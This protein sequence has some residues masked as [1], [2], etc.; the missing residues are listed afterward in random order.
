MSGQPDRNGDVAVVRVAPR[1]V[2]QAVRRIGEPVQHDGGAYGNAGGLM[3]YERF[4]S[5]ANLPG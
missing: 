3:M 5:V 4:Q 1:D 2:T